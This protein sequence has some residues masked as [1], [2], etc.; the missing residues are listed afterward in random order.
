VYRV[1]RGIPVSF[2][3]GEM[4][5]TETPRGSKLEWRILLAS[6]V[7][8]FARMTVRSLEAGL[9]RGLRELRGLIGG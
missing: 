6:S 5:V 3:R 2:H 9:G 7:P 1:V 8:G 4:L